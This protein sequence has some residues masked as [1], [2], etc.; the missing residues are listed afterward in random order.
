MTVDITNQIVVLVPDDNGGRESLDFLKLVCR[1]LPGY[2]LL[3]DGTL[4]PFQPFAH[5][6][7]PDISCTGKQ[8]ELQSQIKRYR[9]LILPPISDYST[10]IRI[11]VIF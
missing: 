7:P 9:Q 8:S 6:L 11:V 1:Y 4:Q 5:Q 10:C 3:T 2:R